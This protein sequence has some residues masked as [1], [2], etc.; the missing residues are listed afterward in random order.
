MFLKLIS[1]IAFMLWN[2]EEEMID[3]FTNHNK[4]KEMGK[5]NNFGNS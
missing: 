3:V 2:R 4:Y 1:Q 5:Q